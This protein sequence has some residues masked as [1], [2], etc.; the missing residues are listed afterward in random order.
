[1]ECIRETVE[2]VV[3][4]VV[5]QPRSSRT[6]IEGIVNGSL[7]IKV[8]SPPVEGKANQACLEFLSKQLSIPKTHMSVSAGQ[9]TRFKSITIVGHDA[10]DIRRSL[11][12]LL[13]NGGGGGRNPE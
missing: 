2:G 5:L 11:A 4:R 8:T 9:K 12:A 13:G 1:M 7:K 6:A 10:E 3:L